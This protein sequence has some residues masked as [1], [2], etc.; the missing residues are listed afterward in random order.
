MQAESG[1]S[2]AESLPGLA[3]ALLLVLGLLSS[4]AAIF[5]PK[6]IAPLQ[7]IRVRDFATGQVTE[8]QSRLLNEELWG[9]DIL[10]A[11]A[12]AIDWWALRDLG[13]QVR[14][15]CDGWLF[16]R[17]EL[18]VHPEPKAA[19]ARRAAMVGRVADILRGRNI[20]LVVALAPD[21][22]RVEAGHLCRLKRPARLAWRYQQFNAF[23]GGQGVQTIDLFHV[24]ERLEGERY[25]LSDTH[26]N[27]KGA[28]AAADAIAR[29]LEERGV[30][31]P[32]GSS[33]ETRIGPVVR[34]RVGDLIRLAGLAD[35][36]IPLRPAGDWV[37]ESETILPE[38]ASDDLLGEMAGPPVVVVGSSFSRNA[39]FVGFL[40]AALSSPVG[41][42]AQD[43]AKFSA[44]ATAYFK[45][46]AFKESPPQAI[47][48]EIPE[49]HVDE[50]LSSE[51]TEWETRLARGNL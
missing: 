38:P 44:A 3:L 10:A 21:K 24:L 19:M 17:E 31:P 47:V 39:N 16:L 2:L 14:R 12:R 20:F 23:I 26:W 15:G 36:P 29:H 40:A 45:N 22:S 28:K 4:T 34:E 50:A 13:G 46:A 33:V 43:G 35:L 8:A 11:A 41:N 48:W 9:G 7:S 30:A 32:R 37:A 27:E 51:E 25:F 6:G 1:R 49:R 42:L 5:S 18:D